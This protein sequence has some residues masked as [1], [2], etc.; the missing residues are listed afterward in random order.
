[1]PKPVTQP[2]PTPS[3]TV[4]EVKALVEQSGF[5]FE[6]DLTTEFASEGLDPTA[7]FRLRVTEGGARPMRGDDE[8]EPSAVTRE[9]DVMARAHAALVYD[10][11]GQSERSRGAFSGQA[12][13]LVEAKSLAP[14]EAFVG[15]SVPSPSLN[16]LRAKRARFG[17]SPCHGVLPDYREATAWA[18]DFAAVLD[19]LNDGAP[20]CIQWAN[21]RRGKDG[22]PGS[23]N[24]DSRWYAALANLSRAAQRLEVEYS[25]F[26]LRPEMSLQ[27]QIL[28]YLPT[29]LIKAPDLY[30][31]DAASKTVIPTKRL[32]LRQVFELADGD[33]GERLVDVYAGTEVKDFA[34]RYRAI[35]ANMEKA[36]ATEGFGQKIYEAA[37]EQ[38]ERMAV[39]LGQQSRATALRQQLSS[40]QVGCLSWQSRGTTSSGGTANVAQVWKNVG[41]SDAARVRWRKASES[42]WIEAGDV[43]PGAVSVA[44]T[45]TLQ[46]QGAGPTVIPVVVQHSNATGDIIE[47]EFEYVYTAE[48]ASMKKIRLRMLEEREFEI[49]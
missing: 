21:V 49:G 11:F 39:S 12:V 40:G 25:N 5:P 36:I 46:P 13:A 35:K 27:T 4:Q 32:L 34:Q 17:G 42:N 44:S 7:G 19:P 37:I 45:L 2:K 29:L 23:A 10:I 3:I 9:V 24:H 31:Y 33:I 1:M 26:I 48:K 14:D 16:D 47:E 20:Y 15:F 28:F 22:K 8:H 41:R 18:L 6:I 43:S 30:L 38:R